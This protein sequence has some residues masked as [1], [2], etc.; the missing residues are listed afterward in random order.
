MNEIQQIISLSM[1][2]SEMSREEMM[3]LAA[4]RILMMKRDVVDRRESITI[5]LSVNENG[6]ITEE[7]DSVK[8]LQMVNERNNDISLE[9]RMY[10]GYSHNEEIIRDVP[11]ELGMYRM[12]FRCISQVGD[13]LDIVKVNIAVWI[14]PPPY[15]NDPYK[16]NF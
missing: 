5:E 14:V 8:L 9:Y 13:I 12:D 11:K 6:I 3:R 4:E 7:F 16:E 2:L 10:D 1:R 15:D